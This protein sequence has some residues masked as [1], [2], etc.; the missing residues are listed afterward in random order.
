MK[1]MPPLQLKHKQQR[2]GRDGEEETQKNGKRWSERRRG[3]E[4]QEAEK[5]GGVE[6]DDREGE[7]SA[8]TSKGEEKVKEKM[9]LAMT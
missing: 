9:S 1:R 7:R 5:P 2:A 3:G 8:K 6:K 4:E